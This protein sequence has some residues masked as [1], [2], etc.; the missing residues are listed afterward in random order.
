MVVPRLWIPSVGYCLASI[1]ELLREYRELC[2][3]LSCPAG[4][5]QRCHLTRPHH[6]ALFLSPAQAEA[7]AWNNAFS[8]DCMSPSH[9]EV[10]RF[11]FLPLFCPHQQALIRSLREHPAGRALAK[12]IRR[13]LI[14]LTAHLLLSLTSVNS[15][16][17]WPTAK[18]RQLFV[19]R[20][21]P[22]AHPT[23]ANTPSL[24]TRWFMYV[25]M[26]NVHTVLSNSQ[27]PACPQCPQPH[28]AVL[29]WFPPLLE[30]WSKTLSLRYTQ[31]FSTAP[32]RT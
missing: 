9:L 11:L 14:T 5:G 10:L 30:N 3:D 16:H 29:G 1:K 20:H 25:C 4:W 26:Q 22:K 12:S 18:G 24:Y 15:T 13:F 23:K 2:P 6:T 8:F 7:S 31:I 32:A 28:T 17:Q 19:P 21:C 27:A